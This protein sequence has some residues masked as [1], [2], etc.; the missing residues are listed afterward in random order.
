MHFTDRRI[1]ANLIVGYCHESGDLI[2]IIIIIM[3]I[4]IVIITIIIITIHL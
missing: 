2:I 4:I 1:N 3:I